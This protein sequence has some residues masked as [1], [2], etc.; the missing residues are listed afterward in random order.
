MPASLSPA[1]SPLLRRALQLDAA[2]SGATALLLALGAAPLSGPLAL[3]EGLLRGAGVA[4][5]PFVALLGVL[6]ARGRAARPTLKAVV[7]VNALWAAD[8]VLLLL[9]GWVH[10]SALG[11]AFVLAQAAAVGGFA[12]LQAAGLRAAPLAH[13]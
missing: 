10:P 13:A 8:S 6:V 9:T 3:P 1:L 4:L 11:V 2:A 5:L 12:V 7:A